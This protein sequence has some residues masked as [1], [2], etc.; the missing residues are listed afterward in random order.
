LTL[1]RIKPVE[2]QEDGAEVESA[3]AGDEVTGGDATEVAVGALE[4]AERH[5]D[6]EVLGDVDARDANATRMV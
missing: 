4:E 3:L 1:L 5:E 2:P 6:G